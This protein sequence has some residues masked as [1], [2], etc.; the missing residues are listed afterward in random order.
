MHTYVGE[1]ENESNNCNNHKENY[2][3]VTIDKCI[4]HSEMV[5]VSHAAE[6]PN[7]FLLHTKKFKFPLELSLWVFVVFYWNWRLN[8]VHSKSF[9]CKFHVISVI[10][11]YMWKIELSP[12]R[13]I[14]FWWIFTKVSP[15]VL[16]YT[17]GHVRYYA[18]VQDIRVDLLQAW[19]FS[20]SFEKNTTAVRIA[21]SVRLLT[22][23]L[24]H[25]K[26]SKKK[27]IVNMCIESTQ[28]LTIVRSSRQLKSRQPSGRTFFFQVPPIKKRKRYINDLET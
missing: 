1:C 9:K 18:S 22:H 25:V 5:S 12:R 23:S 6:S 13:Y 28:L 21:A 11:V 19:Y 15:F 8:F 27:H 4:A 7:F 20:L 16:R 26:F 24:S 2:T 10:I 14:D 17:F 3:F